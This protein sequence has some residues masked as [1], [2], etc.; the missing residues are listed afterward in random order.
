VRSGPYADEWLIDPDNITG[1]N[2]GEDADEDTGEDREEDI[3][4]LRC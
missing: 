3:S 4:D 2:S 1:M